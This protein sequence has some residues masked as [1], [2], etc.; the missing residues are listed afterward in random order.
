[1]FSG[2][3][4]SEAF[5]TAICAHVQNIRN[6]KIKRNVV[7]DMKKLFSCLAVL[8][9]MTVM[10]SCVK[11]K[12]DDNDDSK[13]SISV[14]TTISA[15]KTTAAPDN[16][17]KTARTTAN[18]ARHGQVE[19]TNDIQEITGIWIEENVLYPRTLTIN[20]DGSFEVRDSEGYINGNV[21][22][23]TEI[24][25]EDSLMYYQFCHSDGELWEY[26]FKDI[27][28]T[29]HDRI[30]AGQGDGMPDAGGHLPDRHG[31]RSHQLGL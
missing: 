24:Y 11:V 3:L 23:V 4:C 16:E 17:K 20:E 30:T 15:S 14:T 18:N 10:V 27:T 21:R 13:K 1:M 28:D 2:V 7:A 22:L 29:E 25:P 8:L 9:M 26:F 12:K 5:L 31:G 19:I 6:K